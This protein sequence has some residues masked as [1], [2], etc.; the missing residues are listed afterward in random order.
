MTMAGTYTLVW[1]YASGR[2]R[3]ARPRSILV[4]PLFLIGVGV[5]WIEPPI[6]PA[7]LFACVAWFSLPRRHDAERGRFTLPRPRG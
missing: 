6:S 1:W 3:L 2:G 5:A 7:T 4:T